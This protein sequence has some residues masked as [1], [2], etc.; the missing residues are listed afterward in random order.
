MNYEMKTRKHII[1]KFQTLLSR[2]MKRSKIKLFLFTTIIILN[3]LCICAEDMHGDSVNVDLDHS[4][5]EV[6]V[7]GPFTLP[8]EVNFLKKA[9]ETTDACSES[10]EW[11]EGMI[12]NSIKGIFR[13]NGKSIANINHVWV[14]TGNWVGEEQVTEIYE[15]RVILSGNNGVERTLLMQEDGARLKI[16]KRIISRIKEKK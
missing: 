1:L 8:P 7:R 3:I 14:K 4:E 9:Q 15:D 16:T 6:S 12:A 13:S 11:K 2:I 10:G 5:D